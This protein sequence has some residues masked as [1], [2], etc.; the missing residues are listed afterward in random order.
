V[1]VLVWVSWPMATPAV[2]PIPVPVPSLSLSI[3]A[4]AKTSERL[5]SH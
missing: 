3:L 2:D 5:K 1:N 4:T